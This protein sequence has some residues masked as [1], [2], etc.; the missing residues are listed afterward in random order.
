MRWKLAPSALA[1][2][3]TKSW[4]RSTPSS[5]APT[6]ASEWWCEK[7]RSCTRAPL[8]AKPLSA[9]HPTVRKP[10][11]TVNRSRASEVLLLLAEGMTAASAGWMKVSA[12]MAYSRGERTLHASSG[13][14][15]TSEQSATATG[16]GCMVLAVK[17][18]S[19]SH[20]ARGCTAADADAAS[21]SASSSLS[22]SVSRTRARGANAESD[23]EEEHG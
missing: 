3:A 22:Q 8:S 19:R 14:E 4:S 10:V 7:P 20:E 1:A 6:P 13:T 12:T 15:G 11:R 21:P 18:I 17:V 23:G 16:A 5:S 9:S 2:F